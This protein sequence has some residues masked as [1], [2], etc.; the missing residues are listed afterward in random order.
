MS[1]RIGHGPDITVA[2]D[3]D[4]RVPEDRVRI[5]LESTDARTLKF[6]GAD[7]SGIELRADDLDWS[8][9]TR[10][11]L[12]SAAQD[13]LLLAYG[14]PMP[15]D[16]SARNRAAAS[17]LRRCDRSSPRMVTGMPAGQ[18]RHCRQQPAPPYAAPAVTAIT[19]GSADEARR[20]RS[21]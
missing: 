4:R 7:L 3:L 21:G 17:S 9:S 15:Q 19:D 1:A 10:T 13:L 14:R 2:L 11:P 20:C 8:F 6:F 12:S 5:I 16:T 18:R